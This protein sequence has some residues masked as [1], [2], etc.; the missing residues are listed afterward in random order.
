[1]SASAAGYVPVGFELPA[2]LRRLA[3]L[4]PGAAVVSLY[5]DLDPAEFP[6]PRSRRL[7][8]TALL[9]AAHAQID[10]H[11]IDRPSKQSLRADLAHAREFLEEWQ[12]RRARSVA[13]FSAST[14]GFFETVPLPRP[15][16]TR[17]F[18]GDSPYVTP[19]V[20]AADV[21][22]WLI[23]LVDAR[24]ARMLHGN[25]DHVEEFERVEDRIGIHREAGGP[26][27][28]RQ[29][30]A[31]QVDRHLE[32]V[33]RKAETHLRAASFREI[34]VGGPEEM[35][36][37]FESALALAVRERVAGRFELDV[38]DASPEEIRRAAA[39]CFE[40]EER[41][42]QRAMVDLLSERLG[43]GSRAVAG[44]HG[45]C[46]MLVQQRVAILLFEEQHEFADPAAIEWMVEEAIEQSAEILAVRRDPD[47]LAVPGHVAAILRF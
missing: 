18:I 5:L 41:R 47:G 2:T 26:D 30:V 19:L 28:Y 42:R 13:L 46:D 32:R 20:A 15:T 4:R 35:A 14:A 3:A 8:I 37:R 10:D 33:A 11:A 22:D 7:A 40:A 12:P 38:D 39:P 21:R 16:R 1:M 45:V 34:I 9:D 43:R 31:M 24:V 29:W 6:T 25:T 17:A 44:T 27:G 36:L 23:V